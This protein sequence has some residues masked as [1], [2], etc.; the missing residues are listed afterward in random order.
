MKSDLL[1]RLE[2]F[3]K[4]A[5]LS[6]VHPETDEPTARA[7]LSALAGLRQ[8]E[9]LWAGDLHLSV[10]VVVV[11]SAERLPGVE[12][13]R[14][15]AVLGRRA[16]VLS[17]KV[18]GQVQVLQLALYDRHVPPEERNFVVSKGRVGSFWPWSRARVSTWVYALAEPALHAMPF[19]GWP[20]ELAEGPLRTLL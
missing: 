18:K 16:A 19:R 20:E 11:A 12:L 10:Q 3:F 13:A 9:Q 8:H 7:V 6:R 15:A 4:A 14:R 5:G 2:T 1:P 17:G